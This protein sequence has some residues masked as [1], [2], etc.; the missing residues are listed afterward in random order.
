M[1]GQPVGDADFATAEIVVTSFTPARRQ[2]LKGRVAFCGP[3][4]SGKTWTALGWARQL[5]DRVALIDTE[6]RSA[7]LYADEFQ[8]DTCAIDPPY[9]PQ[10]LTDALHDAAGYDVVVCDSIS[11]FWE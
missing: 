4:G 2:A 1:V 3:T 11:H 8:F 6:R 7:S 9:N 5:G 10:K